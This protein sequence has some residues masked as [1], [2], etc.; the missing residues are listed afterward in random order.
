ML[1]RRSSLRLCLLMVWTGF[2]LAQTENLPPGMSLVI[3]DLDRTAT[4]AVKNPND[5]G[6]TLAVVT[7]EGLA[8]TKSYGRATS[9]SAYRIGSGAFT[10]VMLL[11]L[12]RAG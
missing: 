4:E 2:A 3:R 5:I 9:E 7:R 6:Y 12:T 8:W 10:A 1:P 11:Q